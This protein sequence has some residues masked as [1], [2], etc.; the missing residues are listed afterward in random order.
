MAQHSPSVLFDSPM[1]NA[2]TFRAAQ[3]CH[4]MIS[5]PNTF[6]FTKK[7]SPIPIHHNNRTSDVKSDPGFRVI[8]KSMAT[9]IFTPITS[10][11]YKQHHITPHIR[12]L[13]KLQT[14][15][16]KKRLRCT[17]WKTNRCLTQ[18]SPFLPFILP[19]LLAISKKWGHHPPFLYSFRSIHPWQRNTLT[20]RL[21]FT[22]TQY[23]P[24]FFQHE[25]KEEPIDSFK[26]P[27]DQTFLWINLMNMWRQTNHHS[28]GRKHTHPHRTHTHTHTQP[29]G[30]G[31]WE[32][33]K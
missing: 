19:F 27:R 25:R 17:G 30:I 2:P 15:D 12:L 13:R 18:A 10:K 3:Q 22:V 16:H 21:F 33:K 5:A 29:S 31:S 9:I 1:Y 4:C 23:F 8:T 14:Q 28:I 20:S 6:W 32:S 11:G 24:F 7:D 26:G